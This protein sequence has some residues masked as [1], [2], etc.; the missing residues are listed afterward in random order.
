[1]CG[2]LAKS[3][4]PENDIGLGREGSR[5]MFST[6]KMVCLKKLMHVFG[7]LIAVRNKHK[8]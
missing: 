7:E 3:R 6:L 8:N 1:M 2:Y 5:P 4:W